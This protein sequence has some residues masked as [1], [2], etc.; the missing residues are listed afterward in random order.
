[1]TVIVECKTLQSDNYYV[2]VSRIQL[3]RC[4]DLRIHALKDDVLFFAELSRLEWKMFWVHKREAAF[5]ILPNPRVV[6][7]TLWVNLHFN[8]VR[9]VTS[10]GTSLRHEM[11]GFSDP[12]QFSEQVTPACS[13]RAIGGAVP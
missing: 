2:D 9:S 12:H 7:F 8:L 5:S 3:L 4:K 1:M 11:A 10:Y 13:D 6:K